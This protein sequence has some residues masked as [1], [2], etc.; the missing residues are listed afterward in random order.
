MT[1]VQVEEASSNSLR[2]GTAVIVKFSHDTNTPP[3]L[4]QS[5]LLKLITFS[6][7]HLNDVP[8]VGLWDDHRTLAIVFPTGAF[9]PGGVA[10]VRTKDI[11]LTFMGKDNGRIVISYQRVL[12]K[13]FYSRSLR[14][15]SVTERRRFSLFWRSM[16][17]HWHLWRVV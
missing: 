17:C 15:E 4:S 3:V 2:P 1:S 12:M 5:Q 9:Y 16:P 10:P 6:P 14:P 8:T 13:V 7:D 11:E